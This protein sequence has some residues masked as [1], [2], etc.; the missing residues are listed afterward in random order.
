MPLRASVLASASITPKFAYEG[1]AN[2][3]RG[4]F[5]MRGLLSHRPRYPYQF[6]YLVSHIASFFIWKL[7]DI[8]IRCIINKKATLVVDI[9][10]H[11]LPLP[12]PLDQLISQ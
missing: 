9:L 10:Y 8:Y 5:A 12:L 11:R 2:S 3:L 7:K 6:T 4:D 1:F